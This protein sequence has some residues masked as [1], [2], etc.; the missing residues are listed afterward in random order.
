MRLLS[1]RLWRGDRAGDAGRRL[2]RPAQESLSLARQLIEQQMSEKYDPTA[3]VDEVR[4]RIEA[5]I[6][7]KVQGEEISITDAVKNPTIREM[8]AFLE[9]TSGN[10]TKTVASS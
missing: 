5:E 9:S 4:G 2:V 8:A 1:S 6:Q 3:Y 7:K 10:G